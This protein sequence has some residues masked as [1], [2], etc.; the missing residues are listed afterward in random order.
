MRVLS[1]NLVHNLRGKRSHCK[2]YFYF[3]NETKGTLISY[4]VVN[5]GCLNTI[6]VVIYKFNNNEDNVTIF[7]TY[8]ILNDDIILFD[9]IRSKRTS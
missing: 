4:T 2:K 7:L 5:T 9:T 3:A 8:I 6:R 1:K